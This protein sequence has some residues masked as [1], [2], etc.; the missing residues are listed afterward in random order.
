VDET[1]PIID[2]V[3]I[4]SGF[5][6]AVAAARLTEAGIAVTLLER[7]P[8]RDTVATR[9]AGIARTVPFPRDLSLFTRMLRS[10]RLPGMPRLTLSKHALFELHI[11]SGVSVICSSSVG[12]GSHVYSGLQRLPHVA[13]FWDG[14][15][16]GVSTS[17][18]QPHYDAVLADMGSPVASPALKLPNTTYQRYANSNAIETPPPEGPT[19]L[20][21]L[22]PAEPGKPQRITDANGITRN[23]V[24]VA[25]NDDGFLGSPSGAKTSLDIA[26][27]IPAL[28]KG[29][30]VRDLCEVDSIEQ[31]GGDGP[32]R[33]AVHV[34]DHDTGGKQRLLAANVIVA[35]GG[36]NTLRL[37]LR[38]R[39]G[40]KTLS[41]MPNLGRRFGCNGDFM[42]WWD[43]SDYGDIITGLPARGPFRARGP[44]EYPVLGGGAFPAI[45][46]YPIPN[47]LKIRLRR[48]QW[49]AGIGVDAMDGVARW[50]SSGLRIDFDGDNSPVFARIKAGVRALVERT[51]KRI[52]YTRN[53]ITVHP[54]GGACMGASIETSV[55]DGNGEVFDHPGL[56]IADAAALPAEPG[57]PPSL[58]IAAWASHVAARFIERRQHSDGGI[59]FLSGR[60]E[61]ADG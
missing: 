27:L 32:A 25:A 31:L 56:Y 54:T 45:D 4:G 8:W 57:G 26:Y 53:P 51:G 30:K 17:V 36:L 33:Y 12:G 24:D 20:G 9:S 44:E 47:F 11:D 60:G 39:D 1:S 50:T 19:W 14:H 52:H 10:L 3:V 37:L 15:A 29:L 16:T 40:T 7:G 6:G 61:L 59:D 46:R 13:N 22:F 5:G 2:V 43:Q 48:V 28:R 35:A 42:G 41:G 38:S 49:I 18:L 34:V 21:F 55:V 58:T 23:Q